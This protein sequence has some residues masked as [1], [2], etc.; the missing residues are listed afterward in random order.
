M[1]A[2]RRFLTILCTAGAVFAMRPAMA[3][4]GLPKVVVSKDPSCGCCSGWVE[5]MRAAGFPV[6][7]ARTKYW[8][9]RLLYDRRAPG[10]R[11]RARAM[12]DDVVDVADRFGMRLLGTQARD[13]GEGAW[14]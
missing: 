2:R 8:H 10:D 3:E 14:P 1:L 4:A 7:M 12:L 13:L 5:H 9:A 11:V 6:L